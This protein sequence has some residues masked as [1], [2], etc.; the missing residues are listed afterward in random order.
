VA[1]HYSVLDSS[2]TSFA[3]HFYW[4]LAQDRSLGQS[5]R[6]ARIAVNYFLHGEPIDWAAPVLYARDANATLCAQP[7]T[8]LRAPT[9]GVR[10]SA[11]RSTVAHVARIAVWDMDNAFPALD[12]TVEAM[13]RAQGVFGFELVD[14]SAPL[15]IWDLNTTKGKPYLWA[16]RL[17]GRLKRMPM[18]LGVEALVC[19]TRHWMRDDNWL[20]LYG[21]WP[22]GRASRLKKMKPKLGAK[23]DALEAL[24]KMFPVAS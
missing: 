2:A 21:W 14:L 8:L 6:E 24:L 19:V 18:E 10:A 22:D 16:E 17:A 11:R 3:Q 20:N 23:L 5:A 12:K 9:T 13:N 15:G 4:S 7:K 1:N